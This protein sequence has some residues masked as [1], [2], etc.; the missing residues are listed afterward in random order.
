[1]GGGKNKAP[2]AP[3]L[4]KYAEASLESARIWESFAR[5]QLEWAK[6]TDQA[7]RD[8]LEQVLGIQ[9][10][11]LESAYEQAMKDRQRYEETYQPV[12]DQ[13]LADMNALGTPERQEAEA[14]RRIA[15][16]RANYEAQRSN[17]MRSLEDY[18]IDPSQTRWQA[19]DLGFRAQEAAAAAMAANQG[20]QYEEQMG[21]ALRSEAI[22]IGRG[23]PGQVA[24]AQG[25]VNQ[26]AGGAMN[27][28]NQTAGT[29]AAGFNSALGAGQLAMGGYGQG[30][31]IM[32]QGYNNQMAQYNANAGQSAAFWGGIGALGGAAIGGPF[33]GAFG[34]RLF[35]KAAA[36]VPGNAHEGGSVPGDLSPIPHP[37]DRHPTML[38]DNEYVIPADVV[39]RKGTEFFDKLLDRYKD[40][41]QYEQ[42]KQQAQQG[43]QQALPIAAGMV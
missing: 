24:Q 38:A 36:P 31:N 11:Q 18:G 3:D 26:T 13:L 14:A 17:A 21:R 7:N 35:S 37:A 5:D 9:I 42:Q 19:L 29:S 1:M 20:R 8:I 4:T 22:N 6:S 12:E 15:D 34:E 41:G 25:I 10:Q 43:P 30:A 2:K 28:A 16:V 39:M 32:S 27:N 23:Y 40:N 33:G